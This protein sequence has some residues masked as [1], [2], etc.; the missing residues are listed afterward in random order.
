MSIIVIVSL[1]L[2]LVLVY[3]DYHSKIQ[4]EKDLKIALFKLTHEIKNPLTVC[5]GYLD[6]MD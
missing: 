2:V 3:R 1:L 4:K 5:K 6:M